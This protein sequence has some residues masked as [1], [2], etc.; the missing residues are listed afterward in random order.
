MNEKNYFKIQ[1]LMD[2]LGR[3]V[4]D[5]VLSREFNKSQE[6]KEVDSDGPSSSF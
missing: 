4:V 5:L 2:S 3:Q 6:I 1:D